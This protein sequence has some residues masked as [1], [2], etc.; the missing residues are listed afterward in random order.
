MVLMVFFSSRISPLTSDR[1]FLGKVA[2]GY[3]RVTSAMFLTWLVKLLAIEL[4][5]PVR[6]FQVPARL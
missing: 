4:T 1:D 5:C 2:I 6:S 3:G